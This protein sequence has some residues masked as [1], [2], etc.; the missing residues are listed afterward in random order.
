MKC[1]KLA[2]LL[3]NWFKF[4]VQLLSNVN[5]SFPKCIF[6][7]TLN[8]TWLAQ[9]LMVVFYVSLLV[10]SKIAARRHEQFPESLFI[11]EIAA[12]NANSFKAALC[13]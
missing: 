2:L 3:L 5:L 1:K 9:F 11:Y 12:D 10:N 4:A 8:L 6:Y 13:F 7:V